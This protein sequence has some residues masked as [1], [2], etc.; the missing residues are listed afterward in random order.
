MERVPVRELNQH[1]SAVLAR[2][3]T[4]ETVEITKD[5]KPVARLVPIEKGRSFLD[6]LVAEGRATPA[7]EHGPFT[8]PPML[9]D[10]DVN[11][12]DAL[13]AAREDEHW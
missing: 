10:R 4:G 5:G 9:G 8:R 7:T 12:A 2:V 13:I 6:R 11:V 3:E 1:T